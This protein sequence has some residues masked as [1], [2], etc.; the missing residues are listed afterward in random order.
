MAMICPKHPDY[1]GKQ[2]PRVECEMC[3]LIYSKGRNLTK[4]QQE[5]EKRSAKVDTNKA[6]KEAL[7]RIRLLEA[8]EQAIEALQDSTAT[9]AIEAR[10]GDGK[11]EATAV[12]VATDW[13]L[14]SV[15][16]P[17]TVNG[18]NKFDVAIAQE[19]IKA[20]FERVVRFTDKER[21]DITIDELVLFLGGDLIEGSLHLDT[22]MTNEIA[23]PIN[24]AIL[25]QSMIESGLGFLIENGRYK[26][27]TV[28]CHDGNHGRIT[29]RQHWSSRQGNAL[30]YFMYYTLAARF[31]QFRWVIGKG[32]HSYLDV[33]NQTIRFHHGDTIHFG[34][35]NG[36]YTYLNRRIFQWDEGRKATYTVQGHL[37]LYCLGTRK[38]LING[39]LCGHNAYAISLGGEFQPP[40]QAFFLVDKKRGPTVQLPI[41]L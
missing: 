16:K 32:I 34:G 31:P 25:C 26:S 41:L 5:R 39:T 35:I 28:V 7:V 29:Q 3:H 1:K 36:P 18:L 12:A 38:W 23:E 14:G 22:I 2:K 15:V 19:R 10:H 9:V 33:Y 24:Q 27:I 21:Q 13:H 11:S 40:I 17:E 4:A 37:H 6:L 30:E 8:R 20:F